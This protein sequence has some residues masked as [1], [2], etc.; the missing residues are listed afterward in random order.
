MLTNPMNRDEWYL[1][2]HGIKGMRWGVRK[3]RQAAK[4]VGSAAKKAGTKVASS[5]KSHA[6]AAKTKHSNK[7][8]L[9]KA[10]KNAAKRRSNENSGNLAKLRDYDTTELKAA[11]ERLELE[12]RY[13]RA[14]NERKN[15]TAGKKKTKSAVDSLNGISNKL[16][17]VNKAVRSATTL[18]RSLKDVGAFATGNDNK[19]NK[20]NKNNEN[21]ENNKNNK[22]S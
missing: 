9:R 3:V 17:A 21:N 11:V 5:V 12:N 7:V 1:A 8:A 13:I 4:K 18:A 20:N 10:A 19:N 15:L 6:S 16:N 22:K 2:H 14:V